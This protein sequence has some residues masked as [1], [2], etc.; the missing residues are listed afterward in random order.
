MEHADLVAECHK[1]I[2]AVQLRV[3]HDVFQNTTWEK[4]FKTEEFLP[5]AAAHALRYDAELPR[6]AACLD[7]GAGFGFVSLALE[8]LGHKCTAWDA[9]APILQNVSRAIPLTRWHFEKIERRIVVP[10]AI[11]DDYGLIFLHG[12]IPLRD[13]AGWWEWPDYA[14]LAD[15][16]AGMLAPGGR[17][18]WLINRGDQL[19][20][21]TDPAAWRQ[22]WKP[23]WETVD[24]NDNAVN[25]RRAA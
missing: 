4:F 7:V 24:I 8:C 3:C 17:M 16:L 19:P 18:E 13:D 22:W 23:G 9:P 20:I 25:I 1:R 15:N 21:A 11:A 12:V 6:G 10:A 2:D 14:F 5:I